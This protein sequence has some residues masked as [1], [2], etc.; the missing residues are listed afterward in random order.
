MQNVTDFMIKLNKKLRKPFPKDSCREI[1]I[2]VV[3]FDNHLCE[4]KRPKCE[5]AVFRIAE[6]KASLTDTNVFNK[7]KKLKEFKKIKI[8]S[9]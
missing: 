4:A 6:I 5:I 2:T 9:P 3:G 8:K 1:N 7:L